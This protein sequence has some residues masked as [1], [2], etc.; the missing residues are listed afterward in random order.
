MNYRNLGKSGLKVSELSLGSWL[1]YGT[2]NSME[3]A[4]SCVKKAFDLGITS[5][6]TA[7]VYGY[8]YTHAGAAEELLG[9]ILKDY[10]RSSYVLSS[11][12]GFRVNN[13][14]NDIGLS[15]KHIFEQC[16]ESLR[17]LKTDYLDV[18]YC[19]CF[20]KE[21]GGEETLMA[22]NDLVQQGKVLYIGISKW[23][24]DQII[25]WVNITKEYKMNPIV[26]NQPLYNMFDRT[27]E[28]EIMPTCK[29]EGIGLAVFSPLAQGVL[30]GKYRLGQEIPKGSRADNADLRKR[31]EQRNYLAEDKL[32]KVE[33]LL[34]IAQEMNISLS[35]LALAWILAKE[36]ISTAIIGATRPEQLEENVKATD[37]KLDEDTMK[38]INDILES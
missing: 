13:G 16:E 24:A 30:T 6:D 38:E 2:S 3:Q 31:M 33:S 12:T 1:T 25:D 10:R 21:T 9:D 22:L 8:G 19:H 34:K 32:L 17:K 23:T 4:R 20:D 15:R 5:F 26:V 18:Y 14:P 11:K 35:N 37:V 36:E 27:I 28:A 7:D 29:K